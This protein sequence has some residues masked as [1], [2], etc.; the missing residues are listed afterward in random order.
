MTRLFQNRSLLE[1]PD[2]LFSFRFCEGR[3]REVTDV[4]VIRV[5]LCEHLIGQYIR[6]VESGNLFSRLFCFISRE[7]ETENGEVGEKIF[8]AF[9]D[10]FWNMYV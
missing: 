8:Q 4:R 1:L 2:D 6:I 3:A 7:K 10:W 5:L 9:I